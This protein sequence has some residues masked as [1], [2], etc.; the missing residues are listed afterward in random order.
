MATPTPAAVARAMAALAAGAPGLRVP[1]PVFEDMQAEVRDYEPGEP[2]TGLGACLVV[3]MPL[4]ER[5]QNPM[6]HVQGGVVAAMVD[7]AVGPLSYLVAPPSATTQMTIS[8]LAPLASSLAYVDVTAR[9][10]HRVGRHLVIDAEVSAPD[11][12]LLA[13]ARATQAV[14][15]RA[16]A[17]GRQGPG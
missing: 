12:A 2:A 7:N 1:P 14:V 4:L 9:L 6:G 5:Y 13:A 16:P 10:S 8:Y 17:E 3:R 11:G 15:R